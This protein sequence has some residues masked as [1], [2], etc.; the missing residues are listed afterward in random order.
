[1]NYGRIWYDLRI[2]LVYVELRTDLVR[3]GELNKNI[4]PKTEEN[5]G[6]SGS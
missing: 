2:T 5:Q 4:F 3:K 1:M 6:F